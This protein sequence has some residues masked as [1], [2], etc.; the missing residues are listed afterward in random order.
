MFAPC[1]PSVRPISARSQ[2]NV[3]EK[4]ASTASA[5]SHGLDHKRFRSDSSPKMAKAKLT[6]CLDHSMGLDSQMVEY[7]QRQIYSAARSP[8]EATS[9][10]QSLLRIE[11]RR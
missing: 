3:E 2:L 11:L 8:E 7:R 1:R 9:E 5:E 10:N 4:S 6:F